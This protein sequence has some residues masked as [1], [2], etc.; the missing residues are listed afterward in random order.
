[1]FLADMLDE[2][3][4]IA[5]EAGTADIRTV[6]RDFDPDLIVLGPLGG[7]LEVQSFLKPLQA[8]V[9]GGAVML[10]GGRSS[11]ALIRGHEFGEQARLTMLPPLGTPE[12]LYHGVLRPQITNPR[13]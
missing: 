8:Q 4:F 10:F 12:Q 9:Y 2:L 5:H 11:E 6:L 13:A 7:T 1:M 3:G